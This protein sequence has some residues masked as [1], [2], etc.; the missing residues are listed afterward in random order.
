[1]NHFSTV[2]FVV[3][4]VHVVAIITNYITVGDQDFGVRVGG[5]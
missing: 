4:V 1:M 2:I 5:L 3:L